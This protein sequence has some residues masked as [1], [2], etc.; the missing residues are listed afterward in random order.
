[1][2]AKVALGIGAVM[3]AGGEL[4]DAAKPIMKSAGLGRRRAPQPD[5]P[6]R[7]AGWRAS[8][9]RSHLAQTLPPACAK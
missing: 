2:A 8:I 7:R 4:T 1:V 9:S 3:A 6:R 5:S